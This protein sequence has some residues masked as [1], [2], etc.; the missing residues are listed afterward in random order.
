MRISFDLD[1]TIICYQSGVPC[2]PNR[3]PRLFR[4]WFP[5][6]L[7]LGAVSLIR[8]LRAR[9]CDVGVYTTSLRDPGNLRMWFRFYG[10]TPAFI[11]NNNI[12]DQ[13]LKQMQGRRGPSKL[14]SAFGIDLHV[15]DSDGVEQ[16][17]RTHG[18]SV[19]VVDPMDEQWTERVL[20]VVDRRLKYK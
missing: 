20:E 16:E 2:E 8:E 6:P 1:D 5:E 18:F 12:H 14:P 17:G 4:H 13:K 9:G 10:I 3:V 15:D 7:R 11:I 19:V